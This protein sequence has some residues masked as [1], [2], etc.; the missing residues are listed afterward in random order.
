MTPA[1][2]LLIWRATVV[3]HPTAAPPGT[4]VATGPGATAIATGENLLLPDLVQP[5]SRK[6]MSW[7]GFPPRRAAR[8]RRA[9]LGEII[10]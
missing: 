1:G 7:D 8:A 10:A 5:E 2:R 9:L 3:P 4:L 6:A